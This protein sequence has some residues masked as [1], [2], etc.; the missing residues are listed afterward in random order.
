MKPKSSKPS[1]LKSVAER[2]APR[3]ANSP[4]V[5]RED[6]GT[7]LATNLTMMMKVRGITADATLAKLAGCDQKTI[8]RIKQQ[9]MS[10]SV[11]TL[12]AIAS[13]LGVH[14]WHL[15]VPGLNP[16][17]PPHPMRRSTDRK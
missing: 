1:T 11:R 3:K 4:I 8:W 9:E 13:A 6:V 15:L 2:R 5:M 7:I 17:N 12:E 14:A 10:P 16:D